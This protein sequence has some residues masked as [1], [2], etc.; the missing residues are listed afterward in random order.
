M[1]G[2]QIRCAK[3]FP[4]KTPKRDIDIWVKS[5]QA[6]FSRG[7]IAPPNAMTTKAFI[8]HW[9]E[10]QRA[11]W[12]TEHTYKQTLGLM[13]RHVFQRIG[14]I[15]V[16]ELKKNHLMIVFTTMAKKGLS[17]R[18]IEKVYKGLRQA[19]S[20]AIRLDLLVKD[21]LPVRKDLPKGS[22]KQE[23]HVLT[24]DQLAVF[25]KNAEASKY[26]TLYLFL[27][28]TGLRIGEALALEWRHIEAGTVKVE[29][30]LNEVSNGFTVGPPKSKSSN[31]S[32]NLMPSLIVRLE[33]LPREGKF[34]F[35]GKGVNRY[36]SIR[37]DF[38]R[39]L[40]ASGL[41]PKTTLHDLRDTFCTLMLLNEFSPKE[42]SIVMGHSDVAFTLDR[43]AHYIP[44]WGKDLGLR[45]E[46]IFGPTINKPD[47]VQTL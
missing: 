30:S 32:I 31:R 5:K 14:H 7:L 2:K 42:V 3:T 11:K 20:Y 36:N 37:L 19:F 10:H 41:N 21:P 6:D 26:N 27:V 9:L 43:Y 16:Q 29:Q 22:G 25:L 18:S 24:T 46:K 40:A 23:R 28:S 17:D 47:T 44:E 8:E 45:I 15:K 39:V 12:R 1:Q 33:Q 4:E 34:V 35:S 38:K 13:K